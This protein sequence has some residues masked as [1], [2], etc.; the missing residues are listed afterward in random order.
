MG[1]TTF[2]G[3]VRSQNGFEVVSGL[4]TVA[5]I[6]TGTSPTAMAAGTGIT[7]GTGTIHATS[8]TRAG[9]LIE[10][11]ILIDL[12]GLNGGGTAADIIGVDGAASC[13]IGQITAAVNGTIVGGYMR[14][15]EA[16]AGGN[17]DIDLYA[18]N[19][20]TGTEDTAATALA[21]QAILVNSGALSLGTTAVLS[22]FPAANQYLYLA[23]GTATAATYTAGKLEIV[24][25]GTA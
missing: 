25:Y 14:C 17:T 19:V 20:A 7:T 9:S 15:L 10:T 2:S 22:A 1:R 12:T 5:T 23:N 21:G 8:V 3:P 6:G 24:L 4:D 18:A 16:P 13:H 11:K